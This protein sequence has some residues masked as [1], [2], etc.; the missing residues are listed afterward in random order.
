ME[1]ARLD[2]LGGSC[3]SVEGSEQKPEKFK[4]SS[5]QPSAVIWMLKEHYAA[6]EMG[7]SLEFWK[8]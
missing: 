3:T 7:C 8:E 2:S 5:L 6:W 1:L 4:F